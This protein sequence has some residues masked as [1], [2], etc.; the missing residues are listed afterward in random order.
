MEL[1]TGKE[2]EHLRLLFKSNS[3]EITKLNNKVQKYKQH[4]TLF[5]EYS[6]KLLSEAEAINENKDPKL[7]LNVLR[8]IQKIS[9]IAS[10]EVIS[11]ILREKNLINITERIFKLLDKN[12]NYT[13]EK[14]N[15][16]ETKIKNKDIESIN[17]LKEIRETQ[18]NHTIKQLKDQERILKAQEKHLEST[19][20]SK[21]K[22]GQFKEEELE[23][24]I[25]RSRLHREKTPEKIQKK[26]KEK[27]SVPYGVRYKKKWGIPIPFTSTEC[28]TDCIKTIKNPNKKYNWISTSKSQTFDYDCQPNDNLYEDYCK[29]KD[30]MYACK[31]KE[32]PYWSPCR[33]GR[34][35]LGERAIASLGGVQEEKEKEEKE[36]E[37]QETKETKRIPI[38]L[39]RGV[40]FQKMRE[41]R[42]K[43][44]QKSQQLRKSKKEKEKMN[45]SQEEM[46]ELSAEEQSDDFSQESLNLDEF[47]EFE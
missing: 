21:R 44:R 38:P 22:I 13:N 33:G 32:Y 18:V 28:T 20:G 24:L 39:P 2:L 27:T 5:N 14:L 15:K 6:Y 42:P 19:L 40:G 11:E 8:K 35:E 17:L 9:E 36:K 47:D 23:E 37:E 7:L 29:G 1:D 46:E 25:E 30:E 45:I 31:I 34:R 26:I 41:K 43:K 16:L 10:G 3:Q 12:I 4:L